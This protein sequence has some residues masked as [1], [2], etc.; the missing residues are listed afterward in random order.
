MSRPSDDP[1]EIPEVEQGMVGRLKHPTVK[2]MLVPAYR[3]DIDVKL[4]PLIRQLWNVG[5]HTNQ[6]CQEERPGL[7]SIEFSGTEQVELFLDVAQRNYKVELEHWDEGEDGEHSFRARL[8]VLFPTKH[9]PQLVK[10]FIEYAEREA[11][12]RD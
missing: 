9:I 6:C 8:L 1:D 7:A 2:V 10:A 4:A 5:I 3:V 12:R 11:G